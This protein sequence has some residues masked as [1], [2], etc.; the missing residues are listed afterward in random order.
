[1][2]TALHCPATKSLVYSV[3][4]EPWRTISI[5]SRRRQEWDG[6]SYICLIKHRQRVTTGVVWDS[7]HREMRPRHPWSAFDGEELRAVGVGHDGCVLGGP[8]DVPALNQV[9]GAVLGVEVV[10]VAQGAGWAD[11]VDGDGC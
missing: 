3:I 6:R 5:D 10:C 11:S 1:M 4:S 7:R 8:G 2:S 9:G